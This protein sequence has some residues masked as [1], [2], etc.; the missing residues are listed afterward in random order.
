[1][2]Y[3]ILILVLLASCGEVNDSYY[4]GKVS[5]VKIYTRSEYRSTRIYTDEGYELVIRDENY[6]L[7]LGLQLIIKEFDIQDEVCYYSRPFYCAIIRYRNK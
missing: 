1:M 7:S 3:F 6:Q 5:D 4:I 2:R